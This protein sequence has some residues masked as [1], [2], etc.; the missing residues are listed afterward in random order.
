MPWVSGPVIQKRDFIRQVADSEATFAEICADTGI[1]RKTGYKWLRRYEEEGLAGLEERSRAPHSLPWAIPAPVQE[2]LLNTRLSHPTWG[3]RKLIAWLQPRHKAITWPAASSVGDLLR[4]HGLVSAR[5]RRIRLRRPTPS[6][7]NDADGP[8]AAWC[9]DFKGWFL[10]LDGAKC[11]PFTM[12]DSVSRFLLCS[13]HL[14][15]GKEEPVRS[16]M[17]RVFRDYGLP[18]RVHSDNGPPFA[19][20]GIGGLSRLSVWLMRLGI[21]VSFSQPGKPQ[22]NGRHE[23]MHRTL[24]AEVGLMPAANLRLQQRDMDTFRR[25]FNWERP[26]EALNQRTPGSVHVRSAKSFPRRLPPLEYANAKDVRYVRNT[27]QLKWKG[28]L[29][30]MGEAFVG[31]PVAIDQLDDERHTVRFC[32]QVLGIIDERQRRVIALPTT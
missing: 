15:R 21:N 32:D 20:R 24:H 13:Q 10:T 17:E 26:H 11:N 18:D 12:S 8:N 14:E 5:S 16:T 22:Q 2:L 29:I 1:S 23:R 4:R 30:F 25:E 3:P 19:S 7:F 6:S 27:G 28:D 9:M 31:E